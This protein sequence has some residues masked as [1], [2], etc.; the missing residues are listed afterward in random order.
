MNKFISFFNFPFILL[1]AYSIYFIYLI[2]AGIAITIPLALVFF[3]L[4]LLYAYFLYMDH[5]KKP[6]PHKELEKKWAEYDAEVEK[7]LEMFRERY[8]NEL[9][10]L[11]SKIT[12]VDISSKMSA[13]PVYS[14]KVF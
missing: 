12:K 8:N 1:S 5:I 4:V 6:E 11:E 9:G 7:K 13:K 10:K 2:Q 14:K 3:G